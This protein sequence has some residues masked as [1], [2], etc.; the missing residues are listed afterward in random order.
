MSE[1]ERGGETEFR[2]IPLLECEEGRRLGMLGTSRTE[3]FN[4]E[5]QFTWMKRLWI[6]LIG[7]YN[8][9]QQQKPD[10]T[11]PLELLEWLKSCYGHMILI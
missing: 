10:R 4:N 6:S 11:L 5:F 9:Q 7:L 1:T 8:Q 3:C 2:L